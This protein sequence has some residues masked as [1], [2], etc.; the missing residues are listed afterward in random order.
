MTPT[1]VEYAKDH[2]MWE[3]AVCRISA[4]FSDQEIKVIEQLSWVQ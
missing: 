1:Y 3:G 2:H 4:S